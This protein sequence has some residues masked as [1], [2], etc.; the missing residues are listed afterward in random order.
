MEE[1]KKSNQEIQNEMDASR[2]I[3]SRK[4]YEIIT[5]D[6]L[7]KIKED[8][9]H[10][11]I[12]NII[13]RGDYV[14]ISAHKKV[15]K[16][17]FAQQ[18]AC[19]LST[20]KDFLDNFEVAKPCVVYYMPTEVKTWMIKQRFENI[21]NAVGINKD[22]IFLVP[23]F[24]K[25]NTPEGQLILKEIFSKI[26]K[27]PDVLI[28]DA[29]YKAV[30]GS[31]IL[32]DVINTF[33]DSVDMILREFPEC[34]VIVIHHLKK[35]QK[36]D[37]GKEYDANDNDTFGSSFIGNGVEHMFRLE[38]SK[39][40]NGELVL[41]CETQR[42]GTII[43]D[44]RLKLVADDGILYYQMISKYHEE[45]VKI[46]NVLS[47]SDSLTMNQIASFS[48]CGDTKA[49]AVIKKMIK[50]GEVDV[51]PGKPKRYFKVKVTEKC[52]KTGNV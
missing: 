52:N 33:H 16:S 29:L 47:E 34:A 19:S 35:P 32:D 4:P 31:L 49:R 10:P 48:D 14:F 25:Y 7:T 43:D 3:K 5:G 15:G 39:K 20:G 24:F 51:I 27:K 18:L 42:S 22:N 23:T 21:G 26:P 11:I 13:Y 37:K 45:T 6:D 17:I 46:N 40:V 30:K 36:D 28:I 1:V 50:K 44:I 41:K 38:K 2:G 8:D 9:T 12:E